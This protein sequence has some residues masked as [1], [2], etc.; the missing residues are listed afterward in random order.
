[1]LGVGFCAATLA[2]TAATK[3]G[4]GDAL[5]VEYSQADVIVGPGGIALTDRVV[6]QI[7]SLPSVGSSTLWGSGGA[8]VAWKPGQRH[9]VEVGKVAGSPDLRWQ[10]LESGSFPTREGEV[11]VSSDLSADEGVK[12]GDTVRFFVEGNPIEV[13]VVG[14]TEPVKGAVNRSVFLADGVFNGWYDVGGTNELLLTT[15]GGD[16]P[17]ALVGAI[18][19]LGLNLEVRTADRARTDETS[20]L[21]GDVDIVGLMLQAFV[22][23]A[24]V[25]MGLV[26]ANTFSITLAQRSR[27]LALMRCVG[28][29]RRQVFGTVVMEALALGV[30]AAVAGTGFGLG[31]AAGL[32]TVV[33]Q[34]ALPVP[35]SL[36]LPSIAQ[37]AIPATIGIVVTVV[38]ALG[39]ARRATKVSPLTAL[40]PAEPVA[41]ATKAG[42]IR[43]ALGLLTLGAGAF[44]MLA[45]TRR[46][47]LLLGV[48][49]GAIAFLGVLMLTPLIVP[50][51]LRMAGSLRRMLPRRLRGGVPVELSIANSLRN[52]RRTAATASA[53]LIGVTL[54]SMLAVGASSM[55]ASASAA[56]D[57]NNPVDV[58]ISG[59]GVLPASLADRVRDISSVSGVVEVSGTPAHAGRLI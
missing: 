32:V 36:S 37:V 8:E 40:R 6:S 25:V 21:T 22:A 26:I 57:H 35:M 1:M 27:D 41:A 19:G 44:V 31:L 51:M 30:V 33:N 49:G 23:I 39:P 50:A 5:V 10:S 34:T 4:L 58:T 17:D 55:S 59:S 43:V 16:S 2:V 38:A 15:A 24:L 29:E 48:S 42:A 13:D 3:K 53:L 14:L 11:A 18:D 47:S 7:E 9:Y 28:A 54:I 52:P 45:A 56:I 20:H 46:T 12:L